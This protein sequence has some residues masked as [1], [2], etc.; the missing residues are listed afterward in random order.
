MKAGL[1]L[2]TGI[3]LFGLV[4]VDSVVVDFIGAGLS[5]LY[6]LIGCVIWY[7]SSHE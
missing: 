4:A 6:I 7:R 2:F 5:A 1:P 3:I